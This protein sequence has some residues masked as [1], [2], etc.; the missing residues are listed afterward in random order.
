MKLSFF[1]SL[2]AKSNKPLVM[3]DSILVKKLKIVASEN[4]LF[5][6]NN[7]NIYHHAN[8]YNIPLMLL[9]LSRGI[10]LFEKKEWSYDD[11]KNSTIEKAEKQN[12]SID[13]LSYQNRQTIINQKFNEITHHD[14][15]P[16][17]NYLLMENINIDQYEHLN[18]SFK[19]LLPRNRIIFNDSSI[20]EIIEKLEY[21]ELSKSS[22][23]S[24]D[25]ILGNLLIQYAILCEDSSLK[26]CTQEQMNFIDDEIFGFEIL[27]AKEA[28]GVSN[29]LLLKA[30]LEKLKHKDKKILIIKPSRLAC[31]I[32][33]K[34]LL[35]I[36]EH[37]IVE[38]DLTSI[39]VLTPMELVNMHLQK[40]KKE[41]IKD[42]LFI[43]DIIMTKKFHLAEL[44]LCDDSN[45]YTDEFINYLLHIQND[46]DLLLVNSVIKDPRHVY[47]KTFLEESK[48]VSF[49]NANQYAKALQTVS[50]LLKSVPAKEIM[51]V[52]S[53][54]TKENLHE[55]MTF[56]I[57][58]KPLL[59]DSSQNLVDQKMDSVM[60][61]TYDDI[62]SLDV[63]HIVLLD[64]CSTDLSKLNYAVNLAKRSVSIIYEQECQAI[65]ELKDTYENN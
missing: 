29:T 51:V 60:L 19:E 9:D 4:S 59:L 54:A 43:D 16:I 7:V 33:K 18:E 40:L 34:K 14:S 21:S 2:F 47:T 57:N 63:K 55:D 8:S 20:E 22:L 25:E 48:T 13:T 1:N 64:I 41:P 44:V 39:F 11:L 61:S 65:N 3:P 24:Q 35:E 38:I 37:A 12:N 42:E 5:L 30:I 31:D 27:Q 26:L 15:V 28:S 52:S 10:Y 58:H 6:Y 32:L 17:F 62:I 46:R 53:H 36:I 50:K 23:P 56:Y 45:L 49:Y